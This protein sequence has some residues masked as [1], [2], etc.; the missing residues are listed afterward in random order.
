LRPQSL[1]ITHHP[2]LLE[3]PCEQYLGRH[4]LLIAVL[5][6]LCFGSFRNHSQDSALCLRRTSGSLRQPEL[7]DGPISLLGESA[8]HRSMGAFL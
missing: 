6:D 2:Q 4:V 8:A 7:T 3:I 5:S 1:K